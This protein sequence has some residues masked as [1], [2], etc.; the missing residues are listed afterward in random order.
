M[1]DEDRKIESDSSRDGPITTIPVYRYDQPWWN[2]DINSQSCSFYTTS[3]MA[4]D[5]I[6]AS[7][8]IKDNYSGEPNNTPIKN[9]RWCPINYGGSYNDLGKNFNKS[10]RRPV[11]RI[12]TQFESSRKLGENALFWFMSFPSNRR[13]QLFTTS[14]AIRNSYL[15]ANYL[16]NTS[17][18]GEYIYTGIFGAAYASPNAD[19]NNLVPVYRYVKPTVDGSHDRANIFTTD[20]R[21]PSGKGWTRDTTSGSIF[22]AYAWNFNGTS[23]NNANYNLPY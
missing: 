20:T 16:D 3:T 5:S 1:V 13:K 15:Q 22:Y 23:G 8:I 19:S 7:Y 4:C 12:V 18:M 6:E 11:F 10:L 17:K 2:G 21:F 9:C 14:I